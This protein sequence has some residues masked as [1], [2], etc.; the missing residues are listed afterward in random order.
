MELCDKSAA[1]LAQMLRKQ[2]TSSRSITESVLRRIKEKETGINAFITIL[3]E[4]ALK[5]ADEADARFQKGSPK[6]LIDGIP[7]AIKDNLCT[8]GIKT[9]CASKILKDYIPPYNAT[10]VQKVIDHG[11]VLVGKTNLDELLWVLPLKTVYLDLL[12]IR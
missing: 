4:E 10:A 6:S 12:V 9:T 2:E 5:Q 3:E 1:E 8:K 7:V 11:A